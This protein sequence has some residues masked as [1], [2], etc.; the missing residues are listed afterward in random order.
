MSVYEQ[1]R[2]FADS[3]AL[4]AMIAL[5]LALCLWPWRPAA[6][7]HV[8]AARHAIFKDDEDGQ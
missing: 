1:L 7:G 2:H 6:K 5:Y 8:E 3:H 4:V